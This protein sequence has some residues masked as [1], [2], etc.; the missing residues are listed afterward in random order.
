MTRITGRGRGGGLLHYCMFWPPE[1]MAERLRGSIGTG[2]GSPSREGE[3]LM[4]R[5]F[6]C[7][8]K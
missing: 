4:M 8:V 2:V 1:I 5:K 6:S 3:K 7:H